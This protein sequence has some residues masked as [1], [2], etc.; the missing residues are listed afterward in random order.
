MF[1]AAGTPGAALSA[2]FPDYARWP[3][4]T[5]CISQTIQTLAC[6]TAAPLA[7]RN[8]GNLKGGG[9]LLIGLSRSPAK[10]MR[11]RN[12]N[13]CGVDAERAK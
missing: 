3:S 5:S 1:P 7:Y 11:L 4:G 13:A 8:F 10:T 6:K 12:A 2:G 9:D